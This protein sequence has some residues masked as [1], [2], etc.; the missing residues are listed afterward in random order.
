MHAAFVYYFAEY[1]SLSHPTD[2]CL[3]QVSSKGNAV[4]NASCRSLNVSPIDRLHHI[5]P[6]FYA[7]L[8]V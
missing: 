1:D 4:H 7:I 2:S 5:W 3:V 8:Y 6:V